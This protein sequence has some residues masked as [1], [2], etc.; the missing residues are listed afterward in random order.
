MSE[1]I[2]YNSYNNIKRISDDELAALWGE[3]LKN[4]SDKKLRDELIVQYIYLTRYVI[5]RVKVSL[6]PSYSLEDI[7]SFGVEG[8]I[9]AIEKFSPDKGARFETYAIMR[10]RGTIIDKI[11]AQDWLP[12]SARKKIKDV[13]Q[14]AEILRQKLGR[15]PTSQEIGDSMGIEKEKIDAILAD[16][17]SVTSLYDKKGTSEES[18]E[19]IDTIE[20][21]NSIN[22]LEKLEEKDAKKELQQALKCLP[23]RERMIMVLYYHE[24]MTLKEIGE[25]I[26]VSESRVCQLHAQA[27]MK[28]RNILTSNRAERLKK[29]IV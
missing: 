26:E 24:N 11:R 8:L 3:F 23:E 17:T 2:Q 10:I 21:K 15:A 25:T 7:A 1:E 13:K 27:I 29:S 9:D 12:R 28:L 22:P 14:A 6:P 4:R 18:V 16:D 20:D 5:G 19:I